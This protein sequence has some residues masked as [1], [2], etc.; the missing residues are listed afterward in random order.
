MQPGICDVRTDGARRQLQ[1]GGGA[2]EPGLLQGKQQ[3][4]ESSLRRWKKQA[5]TVQ[6]QGGHTRRR[7]ESGRWSLRHLHPESDTL[8]GP[9]RRGTLG[10]PRLTGPSSVL[11]ANTLTFTVLIPKSQAGNGREE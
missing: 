2:H 11:L 9:A 5:R 10:R 1:G 6:T 8:R 4:E 7:F 3:E